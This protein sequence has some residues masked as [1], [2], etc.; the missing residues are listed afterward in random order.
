VIKTTENFQCKETT[1]VTW[2]LCKKGLGSSNSNNFDM[3]RSL[4]MKKTFTIMT[5]TKGIFN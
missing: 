5:V 1:I 3:K 4:L 2:R